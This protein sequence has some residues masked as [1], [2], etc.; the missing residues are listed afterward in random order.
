LWWLRRGD[1][2]DDH[3][4]AVDVVLAVNAGRLSLLI[5]VRLLLRL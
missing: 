3:S 1:G 4:V 5:G 2:A